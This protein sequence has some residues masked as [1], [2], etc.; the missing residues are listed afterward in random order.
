MEEQFNQVAKQA[1]VDARQ[2]A[3]RGKD[4]SVEKEPGKAASHKAKE[5]EQQHRMTR[6]RSNHMMVRIRN[7]IA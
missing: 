4:Y 2:A 1:D 6:M 5:A 3:L 7:S